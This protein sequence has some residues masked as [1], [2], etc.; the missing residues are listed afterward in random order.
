LP[1]KPDAEI[2]TA[3]HDH[4]PAGDLAGWR[5]VECMSDAKII[6]DPSEPMSSLVEA[7]TGV[8]K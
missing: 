6:N 5:R 2:E 1:P 7:L 4:R 8:V 3:F